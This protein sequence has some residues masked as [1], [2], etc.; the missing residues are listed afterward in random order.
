MYTVHFVKLLNMFHTFD[1]AKIFL[2]YSEPEESAWAYVELMSTSEWFFADCR[3]IQDGINVGISYL[4]SSPIQLK[5]L[6][7]DPDVLIIGVY[8]VSPPHMNKTSSWKM[9][10]VSRI[11]RAN[12]RAK[13]DQQEEVDIYELINGVKYYSSDIIKAD[14][15]NIRVLFSM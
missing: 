8:V 2:P 1:H 14:I 7:A 4:L 15:A 9:D 11:S 6:I 3:I 12:V 5:E 10:Q 13:H